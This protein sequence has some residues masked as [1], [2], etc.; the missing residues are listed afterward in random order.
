MRVFLEEVGTYLSPV[1]KIHTKYFE[2]K[3]DGSETFFI[4]CVQSRNAKKC[5]VS[6][7]SPYKG[8]VFFLNKSL[9]SANVTFPWLVQNIEKCLFLLQSL[10]GRGMGASVNIAI[11]HKIQ[12]TFLILWY[13]VFSPPTRFP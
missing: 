5:R 12:N 7:H 13:C 4:V 10:S 2:T 11:G 6:L 8:R 3:M 1:R 9:H